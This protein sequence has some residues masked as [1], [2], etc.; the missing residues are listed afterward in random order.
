ML[1][2]QYSPRSPRVQASSATATMAERGSRR[3]RLEPAPA[4]D[5][6][7]LL[8]LSTKGLKMRTHTWAPKVDALL[9]LELKHP[10]LKGPI[11]LVGRVKWV[12]RDEGEMHLV[13]IHFEEVRDTTKV[14]LIQLIVLELGS[15]IYARHGHVGF[16]SRAGEGDRFVIYGL[17]RQVLATIRTAEGGVHLDH[18]D[19]GATF[20]TVQE[21]L[22][23]V[24]PDDTPLKVVPKI[25]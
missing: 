22:E 11:K 23:S 18:G 2:A 5:S 17:N 12:Q 8:D 6:D 1:D 15:T 13:G 21:A 7:A 3:L 14:A 20:P 9:D 25:T 10:H 16:L 19:R 4:P 24:F